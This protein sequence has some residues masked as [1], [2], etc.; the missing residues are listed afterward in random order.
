MTDTET[1]AT[2]KEQYDALQTRLDIE[3]IRRALNSVD[4]DNRFVEA[5]WG[6]LVDRREY[7]N[8]TPG[9][10]VGT[11]T[12]RVSQ[13]DDRKDGKCT[14]FFENEYDLA[15]IR[16]IGRFIDQTYEVAIN[17]RE[18]LINYTLGTGFDYSFIAP[19]DI[20]TKPELLKACQYLFKEF[21]EANMWHG[22]LEVELFHR[23]IRDG[24]VFAEVYNFGGVPKV[25]IIEP[26]FITEP[27]NPRTIENYYDLVGLNWVFGVATEPND[28]NAVYGY[29]A[30]Y[31]NKQTWE[32]IPACSMLHI[33]RN[34]D[35]GVKRG[36]SDFYAAFRT[37]EKAAK[38]LGNTTEGAAVQACIALIKKHAKGT[39]AEN[40]GLGR[41]GRAD[42]VVQRTTQTGIVRNDYY[43]H[44]RPGKIIDNVGTDIMYG[45]LGQ[46][47]APVFIEIVQAAL[48]IAGA[49]WQMP[50]YMIS[51]DAS[52]A[53]YASTLSAGGPFDKATSRRQ[54]FYKSAYSE[55]IWK[56]FVIFIQN[57]R[58]SQFGI[59]DVRELKQ[60]VA[61]N[62]EGEPAAVRDRTVENTINSTLFEKG[63]LSGET[64]AGR[65]GLDY[66]AEKQ[67]REAN[68]D[69]ELRDAMLADKQQNG[70]DNKTQANGATEG[71]LAESFEQ[72]W[73]DYPCRT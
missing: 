55:L 15:S 30:N 58:L 71:N 70:F 12:S 38:L 46:S 69:N 19:E 20:E 63:I 53:N 28:M 32:W 16:G 54:S 8:D 62:I 66:E 73:G 42:A 27:K 35:R 1:L 3:Q 60:L 26:D 37:I 31:G 33:K 11:Y 57:G 68:G 13:V 51:G 14:P 7:L 72:I 24:E 25:K 29:Y 47:S 10:G 67:K 64:W 6:S 44:E 56:A 34:V 61:L 36:I 45:P 50:E 22:D 40:V 49:R 59:T 65:E 41:S 48:R 17:A 21:A 5:D 2:L 9:F 18:N 4:L 39:T 43:Q 52:N 23:T